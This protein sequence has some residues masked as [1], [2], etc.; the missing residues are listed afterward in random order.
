MLRSLSDP[1]CSS[2][3]GSSALGSQSRGFTLIELLVVI[4]IIAIL[5]ALLL[6]AVQQVREAARRAQCTDHLKQLGIALHSY[7]GVYKK[8]VYR[9]GGTSGPS[10]DN[11]ISN[12][13]RRSGFI[14]LLPYIEQKPLYDRIQAGNLSAGIAP[15]GP[16]GWCSWS[17]WN[18]EIPVLQCPSDSMR[19]NPVTVRTNNYA[20]SIGDQVDNPRDRTD[21][22]GLFGYRQCVGINDIID[23]TSNTIAMSERRKANFAPGAHSSPQLNEGVALGVAGLRTSPINCLA[24][25]SG[26]T[27]ANPSQV[28]GKFGVRWQD[29]QPDWVG[30]TTV[31]PPNGPSCAE[32]TNDSGD[33]QHLVHAPG[34]NH[35]GGVNVLMADGVVRFFSENIDTGNLALPATQAGPSP[36]GV[37]GALGSKAGGEAA[38]GL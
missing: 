37:W 19:M 12:R 29:G 17:V 6:P 31:M 27:Y 24:Q 14:S 15:G 13:D 10:S 18:V 8:F 38:S 26:S 21:V 25:V 16:C 23:G 30:F 33:S 22:R 32:D 4:A 20:F 3:S 7:E 36:Y 35:P 5:V 2:R 9:R 34:S 28:K 1:A 11:Q